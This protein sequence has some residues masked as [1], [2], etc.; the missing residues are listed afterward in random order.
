MKKYIQT[1]GS[2]FSASVVVFLIALPLCLGIAVGSGAPLFAGIIGG[3]VGGMVI[4]AL[5]GSQ[6]SISGPAAGLTVIVAAAILRLPAYEAFLLAVVLAGVFQ[7]ILGYLKAG[8]VADY[9]PYSVITGML[10]AI[11]LIL[12]LKQFPHILGYEANYVG[13]ESF[14]QSNNENTFSGILQ[15]ISR[16][17]PLAII[18]GT[19]SL[20]IQIVW[21][22]VLLKKVTFLKFIPA[23]LV[24]VLV[25]VAINGYFLKQQHPWALVGN[26]LVNIPV[27]KTF[28]EFTT[29]F[30]HP[31][32]G[33]LNNPAVWT[34]AI[35]IAL[36]ASLETLFNIEAADELDPYRRVTPTNRELKAQGVGNIVSGFLGGMP[37][38][39]VIVRTSANIS[40]G[41]KSKMS[42]VIHGALLYL[43]ASFIPGF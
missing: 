27:A 19:I 37:V 29:F 42:A 36:V 39:S 7:I 34:T 41:A 4:G 22:V 5:S 32:L 13:D 43:S 18:I 16:S 26:H 25:G 10:A 21:E 8:I 12:I 24:V 1:F 14:S 9:V 30:T 20:F 6:L 2:D 17:A 11:G 15:A 23:P 31:D 38:T 40:A 28:A 35:T 3:F 33:Y